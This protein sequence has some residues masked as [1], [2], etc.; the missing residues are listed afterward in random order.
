MWTVGYKGGKGQLVKFLLILDL[1]GGTTVSTTQFAVGFAPYNGLISY[2]K[3]HS[4]NLYHE[5]PHS[6]ACPASHLPQRLKQL[7]VLAFILPALGDHTDKSGE[8]DR[9]NFFFSPL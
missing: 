3:Q 6:D 4:L 2:G 1:G 8:V 9:V 7:T 5:I